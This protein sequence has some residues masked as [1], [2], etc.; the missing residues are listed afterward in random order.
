MELHRKLS[1]LK[2][3]KHNIMKHDLNYIKLK[4][5]LMNVYECGN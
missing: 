4:Q 1:Q 3:K 2:K 5:N